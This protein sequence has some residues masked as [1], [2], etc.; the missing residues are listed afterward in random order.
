MISKFS[1]WSNFRDFPKNDLR[2]F[3]KNR[4]ESFSQI[5]NFPK[6]MTSQHLPKTDFPNFL[7]LRS[8]CV[9]KTR[10]SNIFNDQFFIFPNSD[11]DFFKSEVS[12]VFPNRFG[13]HFFDFQA[14][15]INTV[16]EFCQWP[17]LQ[18]FPNIGFTNSQKQ[19]LRLD[20]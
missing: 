4:L 20:G 9:S 11:F 13:S 1:Q 15:Q 6:T 5:P 14:C 16:S 12:S 2:S 8:P 18:P 3:P 7:K 17:V 10:I 19:P